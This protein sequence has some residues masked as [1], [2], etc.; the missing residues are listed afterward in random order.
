MWIKG[1]VKIILIA[2]SFNHCLL[3]LQSL[4][5]I[6]VRGKTS[7]RGSQ[8]NKQSLRSVDELGFPL[9][10]LIGCISLLFMFP[11]ASFVFLLMNAMLLKRQK[12]ISLG[13]EAL[14]VWTDLWTRMYTF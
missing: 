3:A 9:S 13:A 7:A 14:K 8:C 5:K 2:S 4:Q 12:L 6:K 1:E 10:M 11:T